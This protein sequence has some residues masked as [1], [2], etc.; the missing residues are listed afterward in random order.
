MK[1]LRILDK[2]IRVSIAAI[3]IYLAHKYNAELGYAYWLIILVNFYLIFTS[4]FSFCYLYYAFDF[5]TY[6]AKPVIFD[7]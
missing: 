7:I 3:L 2:L 6:R 5:K 4:Y 1:N